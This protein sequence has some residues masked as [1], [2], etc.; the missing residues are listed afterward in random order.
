MKEDTRSQRQVN[1]YFLFQENIAQEMIAQGITLD[2]LVVEIM[3]KP[4]KN[5]LH[6]VFKAI[7]LSMY[8]KDSTKGMNRQELN[9]CLEVYEDALSRIGLDIE[10]PSR[11]REN[12]L[13]FYS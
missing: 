1:A 3:P 4:T 2:K 7:L 8:G 9:A 5:S 10:F 11:D 13:Q 6:E 12:L